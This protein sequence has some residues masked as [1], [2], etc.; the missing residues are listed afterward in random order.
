MDDADM[1]HFAVTRTYRVKIHYLVSEQCC[2][3]SNLFQCRH[4]Y[5]NLKDILSEDRVG[6]GLDYSISCKKPSRA[7]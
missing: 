5:Q 3:L 7:V 4:P 1:L 2:L 6:F